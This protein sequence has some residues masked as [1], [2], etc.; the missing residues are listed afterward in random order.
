M[1]S[2]HKQTTLCIKCNY[3]ADFVYRK[4]VLKRLLMNKKKQKKTTLNTVIVNAEQEI[5]STNISNRC[6]Y[7][8]FTVH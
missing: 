1:K 4:T 8:V 3:T 5:V 7:G 6:L 2:F